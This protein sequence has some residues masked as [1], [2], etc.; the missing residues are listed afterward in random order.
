MIYIKMGRLKTVHAG[1]SRSLAYVA[2]DPNTELGVVEVE[3]KHVLIGSVVPVPTERIK[4][5]C[6]QYFLGDEL[7]TRGVI[8]QVILTTF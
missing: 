8:V 3:G 2:R 7:V 1:S 4:K 5:T 6:Q